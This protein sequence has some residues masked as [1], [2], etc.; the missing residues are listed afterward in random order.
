MEQTGACVPPCL[1]YANK[2]EWRCRG[3][4]LRVTCLINAITWPAFGLMLLLFA[5][6][7]YSIFIPSRNVQVQVSLLN[8]QYT[9]E[10]KWFAI[11]DLFLI[12]SYLILTLW[13]P[14]TDCWL[15]ALCLPV[16]PELSFVRSQ[17]EP[18][19]RGDCS[20]SG[21]KRHQHFHNYTKET[22]H[23][24]WCLLQRKQRNLDPC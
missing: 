14:S 22:V 23:T 18:S 7:K 15:S 12:L 21:E 9:V 24:S 17:Q 2:D 4:L 8:V 19:C 10:K 5:S 1:G 11:F 3:C 6:H 16:Y 20:R 13:L